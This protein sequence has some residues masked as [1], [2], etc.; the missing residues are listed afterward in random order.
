MKSLALRALFLSIAA[1]CGTYVWV[2]LRGV[3]PAWA[4]WVVAMA[5]T[6][7]MVATMILGAARRGRRNGGLGRLAIPFLVTFLLVAGG[8]ALALL[9]PAA[10]EPLVLGLPRRAAV[11]LYGV[12]L[13]P[14]F[15]LPL[16]Y[17][18]TFDEMTLSEHDL[19]RVRRAAAAAQKDARGQE[20]GA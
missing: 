15:V 12:G 11:V 5:T 4:P 13:L 10:G 1:I 6:L 2:V 16:A 14:L 19:E 9:L 20:P 8:F 18:L 7:A 3:A 17:A